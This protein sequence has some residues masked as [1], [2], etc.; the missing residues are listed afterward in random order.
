MKS[1]MIATAACA[2][3]LALA[4]AASA[5]TQ[6][7]AATL[8]PA[9]GVTSSGKGSTMVT[10]D[11]VSKALTY[12]ADY[13]GLSGPATMAHIHGPAEPGANAGVQVPF[14][15][16]GGGFAGTAS[17]T[18]AQAADLAAGKYYVNV[19]TAANPRGE[20]RGQL[21]KK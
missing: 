14:T 21:T 5:E 7:Y 10:F 11:T 9:T 20:I 12:K 3:A 8:A 6:T 1:L 19:H 4:G 17:L 16:A 2:A 18:D 15:A 13:T